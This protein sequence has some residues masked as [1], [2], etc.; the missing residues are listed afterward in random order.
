MFLHN[1]LY[2]KQLW[3]QLPLS[4]YVHIC[5]A[6]PYSCVILTVTRQLSSKFHPLRVTSSAA[7]SFRVFVSRPRDIL[8]CW[9][10]ASVAVED[11]PKWHL[12]RSQYL[13]IGTATGKRP[14]PASLWRYPAWSQCHRVAQ[15]PEYAVCRTHGAIFRTA[16]RSIASGGGSD[17]AI[18]GTTPNG[19]PDHHSRDAT[20]HTYRHVVRFRGNRSTRFSSWCTKKTTAMMDCFTFTRTM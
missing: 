12:I 4:Q 17:A 16:T 14:Q 15:F 20:L 18:S 6:P 1:F 2:L 9:S 11:R 7:V 5:W 8:I 3:W 19:M 13:W 10:S